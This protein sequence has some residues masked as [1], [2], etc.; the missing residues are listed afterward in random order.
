MALTPEEESRQEQDTEL[1]LRVRRGDALAMRLLISRYQD[2]VYGMVK[3]MLPEG[4]EA[5]DL[6]QRAFINVWKSAESYEPEAKFTT[7]LFTI[8]KNLVFNEARRRRRKP[9]TSLDEHEEEGWCPPD[10]NTMA[11]D[12]VL[13][14]KELE[15]A[16]ENALGKLPEKARMAVQLRRFQNMNYEE[17]ADI[18]EMS[19]PAVKSLLFRARQSLRE[20]LARYLDEK[21]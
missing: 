8:V 14:H 11:P 4:D 12:E 16:V 7:W 9:A 17:I 10:E 3:R 18:L 19:V 6:A 15:V 2:A 20:M 5:E 13:K 1:M 21:N